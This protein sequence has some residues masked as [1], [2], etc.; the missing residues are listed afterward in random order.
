MGGVS[1]I[2]TYKDFEN[3]LTA[4]NVNGGQL[5]IIHFHISIIFSWQPD[6]D[7]NYSKLVNLARTTPI[8]RKYKSNSLNLQENWHFL[9]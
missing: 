8:P 9:T 1:H 6:Q 3:A 2:M 4:E 7:K 5:R